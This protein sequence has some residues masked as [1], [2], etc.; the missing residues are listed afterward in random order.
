VNGKYE[1]IMSPGD[2]NPGWQ[3]CWSAEMQCFVTR[4]AKSV[5]FCTQ[6][7]AINGVLARNGLKQRQ[8]NQIRDL[9]DCAPAREFQRTRLEAAFGFQRKRQPRF[10]IP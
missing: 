4:V 10:S 1:P 5:R 6:P 7:P 8:L 3:V 9:R 2:R